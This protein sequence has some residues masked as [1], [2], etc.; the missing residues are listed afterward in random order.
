M[1]DCIQSPFY[2]TVNNKLLYLGKYE[3]CGIPLDE[4]IK[5]MLLIREGAILKILKK[6]QYDNSVLIVEPHPDDFA[7]SALG[8]T[9]NKYNS[10]VLNVFSKMDINSF[11][12]I[13]KI[14]INECEYENIRLK[15]A[16]LS[17]ETILGQSFYSLKL[18][19]KKITKKSDKYIEEKVCE[20]IRKILNE[21]SNINSILIPMGI[22]NHPDHIIVRN[23]ALNYL[24]NENRDLKI[25]LYPEYPYARCRKDYNATLKELKNKYKL[26]KVIINVEDTLEILIDAISAYRS[27]FDDINREQM[28]AIVR[29]D[30]RALAKENEQN[31]LTLVYYEIEEVKN[32]DKFF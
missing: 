2:S 28:L 5:T 8:Y 22:G 13:D 23:I 16:K 14:D 3:I 26:N 9:L 24:L 25:I 6:K 15:E 29:E 21:Y 11:T 10:I 4:E 18:Q 19:S 12:W 31:N 1:K 27:Q 17:V 7:L 32:E 30:C 20:A